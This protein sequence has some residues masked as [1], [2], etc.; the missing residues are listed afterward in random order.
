MRSSE[1]ASGMA[2]GR[3]T[4]VAGLAREVARGIREV[5]QPSLTYEQYDENGEIVRVDESMRRTGAA[6]RVVYSRGTVAAGGADGL[7]A[8]RQE[9][10]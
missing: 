2:A 7:T 8:A 3:G 4:G 9:R 6:P 10:A 1:E 5:D